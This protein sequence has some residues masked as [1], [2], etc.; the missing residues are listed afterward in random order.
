M[1]DWT[2]HEGKAIDVLRTMPADS[3]DC[4]VTSPPYW[5]MRD[6]GHPDQLGLEGLDEYIDRLAGI[7]DEVRRV[8]APR[9]TCWVNLGDGYA[10]RGGGRA[11]GS[12]MGRRYL[13]TPGRDAEGLKPG[14]LAGVPWRFAFEA[15]R[16]GWWL[17]SEV[18][19]HKPNPIPESCK[20]RLGIE[21]VPAYVEMTRVRIVADAPLLNTTEEA[22]ADG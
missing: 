17:R 8:L 21:L 22:R 7:F 18:I 5:R 9:G 10:R 12:D 15:Q 4:V 1:P 6:Y 16:R 2:I 3:V 13:G 19:W 11:K 20:S 14:D